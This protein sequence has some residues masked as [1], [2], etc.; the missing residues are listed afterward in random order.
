MLQ[1]PANVKNVAMQ[2]RLYA[3]AAISKAGWSAGYE[4]SKESAAVAKSNPPQPAVVKTSRASNGVLVT[5]IDRH[6]ILANIA[7]GFRAGSRYEETHNLGVSHRVRNLVGLSSAAHN[8]FELCWRTG[9]LGADVSSYTTR[10]L[11]VTS[12]QT[13]RD[14]AVPALEVLGQLTSHGV[15]TWEVTDTNQQMYLERRTM[16]ETHALHLI[17]LLHSAAYRSGSLANS[18]V[19]PAYM[20]KK[21]SWPMITEYIAAHMNTNEACLIGVNV[22]HDQLLNYAQTAP[23]ATGP[24]AP[25]NASPYLGGERRVQTGNNM[26]HVMI[27]GGTDGLNNVKGAAT[28]AVFC[29]LLGNG[30]NVEHATHSGM[31]KASQAVSKATSGAHGVSAFNTVAADSALVGLYLIADNDS[32]ASVVKA[33]FSAMKEVAAGVKDVDVQH[34]KQSV[35]TQALAQAERD[36][37][38]IEDAIT[39]TLAG[40]DVVTTPA[41]LQKAIDS[42]SIADVQALAKQVLGKPS[43]ACIGGGSD[44]VPYLDTL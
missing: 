11:L 25:T 43:M 42:V 6:G 29:A 32:I 31:G 27:G 41:A 34:A 36:D 12:M 40:H 24:A 7:V 26:T 16:K 14:H 5:S 44:R 3:A 21:H 20:I 30:P 2:S 1:R 9:I 28:A 22:D 38:L 39:Q 15:R 8:A 35:L 19:S 37:G 18:I 23:Y 17:E 33:A 4:P 10:D 13:Y